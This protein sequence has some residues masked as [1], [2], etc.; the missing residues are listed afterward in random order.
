VQEETVRTTTVGGLSR[1]ILRPA[2][3]VFAPVNR[4]VS[5]IRMLTAPTKFLFAV[6]EIKSVF[7]LCR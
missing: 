1:G 5:E 2:A 7:R 4:V 3:S 6:R